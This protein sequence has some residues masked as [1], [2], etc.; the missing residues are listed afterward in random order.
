MSSC[1]VFLW[2]NLAKNLLFFMALKSYRVRRNTHVL[3]KATGMFE[4][5]VY[6]RSKNNRKTVDVWPMSGFMKVMHPDSNCVP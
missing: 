6:V 2:P 4:C 3:L 1:D 5:K